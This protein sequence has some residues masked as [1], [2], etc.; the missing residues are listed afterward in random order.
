[1]AEDKIVKALHFS[2][3]DQYTEEALELLN[4]A[5]KKQAKLVGIMAHEF[6]ERFGITEDMSKEDLFQL[7]DVYHLLKRMNNNPAI[8]AVNIP[9]NTMVQQENDDKKTDVKKDS[10]SLKDD[11]KDMEIDIDELEYAL[12][13]FQV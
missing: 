12:S 13:E 1:M 8:I 3:K 11:N 2:K 5:G 6:I 7:I 9:Q 10:E 4:R